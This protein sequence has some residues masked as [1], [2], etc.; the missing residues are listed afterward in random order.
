[1]GGLDGKAGVWGIVYGGMGSV[2]ESIAKAAKGF[3]A[4]LYTEKGVKEILVENGIAKGVKLE[5]GKEIYAKTVLS[6]LTPKV[7][8]LDLLDKVRYYTIQ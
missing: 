4:E 7:T 3:G 6:N 8:F 5:N 2:S 1:M